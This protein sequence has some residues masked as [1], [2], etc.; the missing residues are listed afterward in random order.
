MARYEDPDWPSAATEEGQTIR[1][2]AALSNPGNP[3]R[4]K[5]MLLWVA[6]FVLV[7]V[8]AAVVSAAAW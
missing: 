7:L 8:I 3:R 5:L 4:A 1:L 6:A 2:A